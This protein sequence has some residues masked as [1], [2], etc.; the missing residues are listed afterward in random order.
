MPAPK[1][2]AELR[3]DLAK[4][5]PTAT[6]PLGRA[7][8]TELPAIDDAAGGVPLSAVTEFVCAVPSCGG[9]LLLAQLLTLTRAGCQRVAL[10]D[11]TDSF[12]PGSFPPDLLAHVLW[13][14]CT[15]TTMALQAADLLARDA[16]LALV[17][18]DLRRAPEADL[19]R[20]PGPQWYRLQRA[21]EPTDLALVVETP[22]AAV[23]SAQLRLTLPASHAFAALERDRFTLT[24]ELTPTLTRQ[25]FQA[26]A[27]G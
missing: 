15:G 1:T 22:R 26:A 8:A 3:A 2:L 12:D 11:S 6:R 20:I 23:P 17:V 21:A 7:L 14:R 19:R 24:A 25:R 13:V 18:L 5:F 27:A 9:H 10:V 16:N 4:R